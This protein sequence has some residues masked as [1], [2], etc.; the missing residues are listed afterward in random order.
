MKKI[1]NTSFYHI[2]PL[3][4]LFCLAT[5]NLYG[6]PLKNIPMVVVQQNG[7]TL[8]CYASGDEFFN[9]LHDAEG[10]TIIQNDEGNYMY[11]MYDG[12][13]I[14]PSQ[15]M[16]GTVNP[17][18]VGL[19]PRV[20]I[21]NEEYQER[22]EQW[23]RYEN[24]SRTKTP[25]RNQGTINNLVV[26]IRF[27][28][29]TEIT[30]PF[31]WFD[32]MFNNETP[33]YNS[34][35]NY[36]QTASYGRLNIPS[37]FYPLPDENQ[38]LSYQDIYPRSYYMPFHPV[39]NPD[40]YDVDD[41]WERVER[42]HDLLR[43]AV[44]HIAASVPAG[45]NIDYDGDGYVDNICF[46]V[47]GGAT[48]WATLLWPHKWSLFSHDVYIHG[49][50]VMEYNFMLEGQSGYFTTAV[51][52]HEMLHTLTFPDLYRYYAN[53]TPTG[54]WDIMCSGSNPPQQ[55][56]S[57]MKWKYGNWLNEPTLI[58]PGRYTLNSVGSGTGIVSYK[59]PSSV[60]YQYFVLEFRNPADP[61]EN[62]GYGNLPGLLIY[63]IDTRWNGNAGYDGSSTFDELYLF[64]PNGIFPTHYVDPQ[65]PNIHN[66]GV[67]SQANF[68]V[69]GR[70]SFTPET[71]PYPFLTN[72]TLV[73]DIFITDIT[74][75]DGKLS[76][77]Y[78]KEMPPPIYHPITATKSVLY[79]LKEEYGSITPEGEV[80]VL[81]NTDQLFIVQANPF[82]SIYKLVVD[83]DEIFPQNEEQFTNM[84]YLFT[85]VRAAHTIEAV[86]INDVGT[87]DN[88]SSNIL[89]SIQPNPA[90]G[91]FE[92][93]LGS[94]D[95]PQ[96]GIPVQI[97]DA[98]GLLIKTLQLY[99]EK[100]KIDISN[101]S[102]G[103]Y[104]VKIGNEAK[105]LIVK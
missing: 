10:Y 35:K 53:G 16:A 66:N 85:N 37:T 38:V 80:F 44:E 32:N 8:Y 25:N 69:N 81:D 60:S 76:F 67:I 28:D 63:R 2:F 33:G 102:K 1:N 65:N 21:S 90:R 31:S 103:F 72:G 64:R 78:S 26:F 74:I 17:A 46:V 73:N 94:C 89:A 70:L 18:V 20:L 45:L 68:G 3:L 83:G 62:F 97:Y 12:N 9:Y 15:F 6:A 42:E 56:T 77:T 22:R 49:K 93:I 13:K 86:F 39:S 51:L 104:I 105:K 43:R 58:Q 99:D 47:R 29:Q 34:M 100:T 92:I 101:L 95:L 36:F 5:L 59:I 24:I 7:D 57:Y 71:N 84:S 75:T 55:T 23:H 61:F 54:N 98:Q 87:K 88:K 96:S 79:L 30:R 50:Q 91:F 52:S 4:L 27:S 82:Y 19:S 14:V 48:A 11:A 40:G 41:F